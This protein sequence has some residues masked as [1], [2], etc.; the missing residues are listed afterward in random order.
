[1]GQRKLNPILG[2]SNLIH[3][4][5]TYIYTYML[6]WGRANFIT[7]WFFHGATRQTAAIEE[8]SSSFALIHEKATSANS[9]AAEANKRSEQA[10]TSVNAYGCISNC[11]GICGIFAG[12][13]FPS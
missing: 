13:E 10:Q 2:V 9:D 5:F 7:L 11:R 3:T 12:V 6:L 8:L 1:M 4:H